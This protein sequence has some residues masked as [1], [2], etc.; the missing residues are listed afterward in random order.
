MFTH[1]FLTQHNEDEDSLKTEYRTN[2]PYINSYSAY[3][4]QRQNNV[5]PTQN[6]DCQKLF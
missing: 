1:Q 2:I 6:M 4:L 3:G 5:L